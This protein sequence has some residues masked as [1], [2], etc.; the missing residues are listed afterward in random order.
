MQHH[1]QVT[2]GQAGGT[3][4]NV[5]APTDELDLGVLAQC[6]AEVREAVADAR[7]ED[8]DAVS[9]GLLHFV[10]CVHR[11]PPTCRARGAPY[12]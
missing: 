8:P 12:G 3:L 5:V 10:V 7:H 2:P 1:L 4:E 9:A 6:L 11:G